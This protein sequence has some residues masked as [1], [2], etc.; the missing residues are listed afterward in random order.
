MCNGV[1]ETMGRVTYDGKVKH[2]VTAHPKVDPDT[3]EHPPQYV[4]LDVRHTPA[5]LLPPMHSATA[6]ATTYT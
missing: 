6:S 5:A 1:V 4:A 2:A 3:G